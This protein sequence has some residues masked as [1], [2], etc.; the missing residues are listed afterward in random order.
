MAFDT[1]SK[2]DA[3][4]GR[5]NYQ[6]IIGLKT[7]PTFYS[8]E[9]HARCSPPTPRTTSVMPG[10]ARRHAWCSNR[11]GIELW[12]ER[13]SPCWRQARTRR[14][15]RVRLDGRAYGQMVRVTYDY[16][17]S[18]GQDVKVIAGASFGLVNVDRGIEVPPGCGG[19]VG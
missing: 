12:N 9:P 6:L 5:S 1:I 8:I 17:R 11:T 19:P 13:S 10:S 3:K 18:K 14:V 15:R 4:L 7:C 2:M 16:L